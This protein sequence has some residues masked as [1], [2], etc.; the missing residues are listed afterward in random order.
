[1]ADDRFR[2][3]LAEVLDQW[4]SEGLI[5]PEQRERI[6]TYYKL[7]TLPQVAQGRF[8]FVLLLLGALLVGLGLI[9][10]IAANWVWIP[11]P[12][13]ALGAVGIMLS[14]QWLGWRR[15]ET[16]SQRVGSALMLVGE[17]ALG[18]SIGLVAQWF[19]VSGS[20]AGLYLAWGLGILGV[21]WALRHTPSAVLAMILLCIG[22]TLD[23]DRQALGLFNPVVVPWLVLGLLLPLAYWC[24]SR[25]VFTLGILLLSW[26]LQGLGSELGS[27]RYWGDNLAGPPA[28]VT[29]SLAHLTGIWGLWCFGHHRGLG[30]LR[31]RLRLRPT[32]GDPQ[33]Q[34]DAQQ[35]LDVGPT[36]QVLALVGLLG[37]LAVWSFQD[38]WLR[39][40]EFQGELLGLLLAQPGAWSLGL[41]LLGSGILWATGLR[42]A[43]AEVMRDPSVA[44]AQAIGAIPL[45]LML[46][47]VVIG[48]LAGLSVLVVNF[49]LF[50][51]ALL[52]AWQGLQWAQ[53]WRFWLGLLSITGL[54][55]IRF[56]EFPGGLLIKSLVLVVCGVGVIV[57]GLRFEKSLLERSRVPKVSSS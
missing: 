39:V 14:C 44:A 53:R 11:R 23:Y 36:A 45:G 28:S 18:A 52:L 57:A 38:P 1:M 32:D 10:L 51:L 8:T 21:A 13:R 46:L 33:D 26:S 34:Q 19:Q 30:W 17:M 4:I 50:G 56:F 35:G 20:P 48:P 2:R 6:R 42:H 3:Q 37:L 41:L 29:L 54:V 47:I 25:W 5:E 12:L 22:A 15:Y 55:L 24:R 16:G 43:G 31:L 9:T 27:W 7:E 49:G 40:S